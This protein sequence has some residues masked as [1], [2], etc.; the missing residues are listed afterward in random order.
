MRVGGQC[1]ALAPLHT[2][3]P[4]LGNLVPIVLEVGWEP[5]LVWMGVENIALL[6]FDPQTVQPTGS[7]YTDYAIP[8]HNVL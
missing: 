6:G 5:W 8:T 7:C 4:Q 2:H 1:H 3:P